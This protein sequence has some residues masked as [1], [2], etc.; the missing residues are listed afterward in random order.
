[1]WATYAVEIFDP[2]PQMGGYSVIVGITSYADA[3]RK[4]NEELALCAEVGFLG[5]QARIIC[6]DGEEF[7]YFTALDLGEA[8]NDH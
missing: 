1:M 2:H 8:E 6:S 4:L 7:P 3:W 5:V